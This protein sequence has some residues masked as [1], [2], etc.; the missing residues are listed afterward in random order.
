MTS[1]LVE[2]KFFFPRVSPW[3]RRKD[4]ALFS[5][6][7][8]KR[9]QFLIYCFWNNPLQY[10]VWFWRKMAHLNLD[11]Q[12]KRSRLVLRWASQLKFNDL[13]NV[14]FKTPIG[15]WSRRRAEGS[16]E[17]HFYIIRSWTWYQIRV[18]S[19]F[20]IF[21]FLIV[22]RS[23]YYYFKLFQITYYCS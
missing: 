23:A 22:K 20:E 11:A 5:C 18:Q 14:F 6:S 13:L 8:S 2:I 12:V 19:I 21:I 7:L 16:R 1:I 4:C 17:M 9:E 3:Y 10:A 15:Y